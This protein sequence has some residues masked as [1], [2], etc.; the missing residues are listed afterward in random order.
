MP[1]VVK[2]GRCEPENMERAL[3][4]LRNRDVALNAAITCILFEQIP[5]TTL[6]WGKLFCSVKHSSYCRREIG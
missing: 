6:R 1:E 4:A 2:Y 3:E 5:N